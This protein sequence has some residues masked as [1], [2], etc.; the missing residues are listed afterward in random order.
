MLYYTVSGLLVGHLCVAIF[1]TANGKIRY[2]GMQRAI[3][4]VAV[5]DCFFFGRLRWVV[6]EYYS[7]VLRRAYVLIQQWQMMRKC[8][9]F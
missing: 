4:W 2:L 8:V 6:C 5:I 7:F 3:F 9:V 1:P